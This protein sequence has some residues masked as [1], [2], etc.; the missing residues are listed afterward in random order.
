MALCE[1]LNTWRQKATVE[2]FGESVLRDVGSVLV[3]SDGLL[4]RLLDCAHYGKIGTLEDLRREVSWSLVDELGPDVVRI[5]LEVNPPRPRARASRPTGGTRRARP[6]PSRTA[7][8][9]PLATN[10]RILNLSQ[11]TPATIVSILCICDRLQIFQPHF[12]CSP[13]RLFMR[14]RCY[15]LRFRTA[16]SGTRMARQRP[17]VRRPQP[18]PLHLWSASNLWLRE[19]A[20]VSVVRRDIIVRNFYLLLLIDMCT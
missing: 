14:T 1:A 6:L 13:H 18:P 3:L 16:S 20:V 4:E 11:Y 2:K 19:C 17:K 9:R 12:Y 5:I 10:S 15:S 8:A 7:S